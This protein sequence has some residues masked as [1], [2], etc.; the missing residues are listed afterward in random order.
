MLSAEQVEHFREDGYLVLKDFYDDPVQLEPISHAIHEIS[1]LVAK[2]HRLPAEAAG[3]EPARFDSVYRQ[4]IAADRGHGGEVYDAIK[5]VPA[6]LRLVADPRHEDII[7]QLRD[8][9]LVGVASGGYGIRIDNPGEDQFAAPWHQEYPAQLRSRDGIIFWTPLRSMTQQ[10]GPVRLCRRS[11][12]LGPLPVTTRDPE[13]PHKTGAYALRL[14]NEQQVLQDQE[15][16]EPL[17]SRGDVL[18]MDWLTIH[19]SGVNLSAMARWTIQIRY[20][21]FT[22]PTGIE[23]GWVGSFAEGTDFSIIHPELVVDPTGEQP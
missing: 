9:P 23:D 7:R 8:T 4:L 22:E 6:L 17:L 21:N 2:R 14:F 5:H 13:N 20:F 19:A 18:V 1:L 12:K 3:Y 10:M 15:I 11:Q 16:V